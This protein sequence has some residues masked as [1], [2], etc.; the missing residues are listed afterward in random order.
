[1]L[2]L[3][4]IIS[5][6]CIVVL[7]NWIIRMCLFNDLLITEGILLLLPSWDYYSINV[8][9][10]ISI[11]PFLLLSGLY[12]FFAFLSN[13]A[14]FNLI[15][16]K[17]AGMHYPHLGYGLGFSVLPLIPNWALSILVNNEWAAHFRL[18]SLLEVRIL[19]ILQ[20]F[21]LNWQLTRRN[22]R[23]YD[24]SLVRFKTPA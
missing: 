22:H 16:L 3:H 1:M 20:V 17:Y 23:T 15:C 6:A 19:P 11:A 24:L 18:R 12:D 5:T 14:T 13:L 10:R 4:G 2:K 21:A 7:D 8:S 9:L